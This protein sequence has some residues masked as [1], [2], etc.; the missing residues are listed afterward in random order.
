[1]G[2]LKATRHVSIQ[3]LEQQSKRKENRGKKKE[4]KKEK[5]INEERVLLHRVFCSGR[6]VQ[7]EYSSTDTSRLC[8]LDLGRSLYIYI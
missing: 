1:M 3:L 4:R 5:K 6:E 2:I 8:K 7:L